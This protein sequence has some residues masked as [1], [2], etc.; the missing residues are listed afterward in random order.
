MIYSFHFLKWVPLTP[1]VTPFYMRPEYMTHALDDQKNML[2]LMSICGIDVSDI[3]ISGK[4]EDYDIGQVIYQDKLNA[5]GRYN[6]QSLLSALN[7]PSEAAAACPLMP[8]LNVGWLSLNPVFDYVS[9]NTW[10][11]TLSFLYENIPGRT[12]RTAEHRLNTGVLSD[13]S[14]IK[15]INRTKAV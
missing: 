14:I 9:V 6:F 8:E 2:N 7:L 13:N 12:L 15:Y 11:E 1:D 5:L 4:M 3:T 10:Y